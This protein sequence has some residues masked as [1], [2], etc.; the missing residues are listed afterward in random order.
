MRGCP[1][2][3]VDHLRSVI[4]WGVVIVVPPQSF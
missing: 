4:T 3:Y 1:D 2:V